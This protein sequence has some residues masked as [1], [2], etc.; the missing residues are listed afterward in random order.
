MLATLRHI[1]R[2]DCV[3]LGIPTG[4][5]LSLCHIARNIAQVP[6]KPPPVELDLLTWLTHLNPSMEHFSKTLELEGVR[7]PMD[8]KKLSPEQWDELLMPPG[9]KRT[10]R[11]YAVLIKAH[12]FDPL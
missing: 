3:A 12:W 4:H 5:V 2:E 1:E 9:Y 6:Q 11:H 8:L 10:L 7:T